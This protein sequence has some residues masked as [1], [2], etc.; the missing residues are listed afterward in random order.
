MCRRIDI[1]FFQPFN[2]FLALK[3]PV[4]RQTRS[5]FF[6]CEAQLLS[7]MVKDELVEL[8]EF[9]IQNISLR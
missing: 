9:I 8:G 2:E 1:S 5:D 4:L 7:T 3:P 6:H